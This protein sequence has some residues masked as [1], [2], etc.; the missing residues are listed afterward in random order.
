MNFRLTL[1]LSIILLVAVGVWSLMSLRKAPEKP[2]NVGQV[3]DPKPSAITSISVTRY[4]AEELKFVKE[5]EQWKMLVPVKGNADKMKVDAIANNLQSLTFRQK[6]EPEATGGHTPEATG[7]AKPNYIIK[8]S[9]DAKHDYT[10]ALGKASA[11]SI[12]ATLNGGKTIY[13]L[14]K[15]D[16]SFLTSIDQ[17]AEKFRNSDIKQVDTSKVVGVT[18]ASKANTWSL[19]KTN[20]KWLISKPINAR[21]NA[22][23]VDGMME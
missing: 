14:D 20:D 19:T 16:N 18:L 5:G 21:A 22:T 13:V 12:F 1:T 3:I 4:G 9:D 8:F 23:A 6:L 11:D 2:T 7:T 10:L 17:N 15:Q